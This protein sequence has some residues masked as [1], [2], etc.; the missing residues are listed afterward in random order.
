MNVLTDTLQNMQ[1]IVP[2]VI[3][4]GSSYGEQVKMDESFLNQARKG[5]TWTNNVNGRG[6]RSIHNHAVT[7]NIG[8]HF[9]TYNTTELCVA[10][11]G[12]WPWNQ[13]TISRKM[14]IQTQIPN[15]NRQ[16]RL[17]YHH[18][19]TQEELQKKWANYWLPYAE[20]VKDLFDSYQK[21]L[22]SS[23]II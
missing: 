8:R 21:A 20:C 6:T 11:T 16:L 12:F 19:I 4:V 2:S 5:I 18:I 17:G 1:L 13:Q 15:S 22:Q 10:W 9:H 7:Y 23:L 14:Q 3:L